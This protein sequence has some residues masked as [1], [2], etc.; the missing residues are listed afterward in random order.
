[1]WWWWV[2]KV[3]LVIG[4]GYSLALAKRNNIIM[5]GVEDF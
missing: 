2:L 5:T 4:F 3:I 1:V